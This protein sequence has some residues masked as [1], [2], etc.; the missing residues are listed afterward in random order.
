MTNNELRAKID[1]LIKA[2]GAKEITGPIMN[3]ILNDVVN[4]YEL[5]DIK[6]SNQ[7]TTPTPTSVGD[8]WYKPSTNMLFNWTGSVWEALDLSGNIASLNSDDI[9]EGIVNLFVTSTEKGNFHIQNTD[10]KISDLGAEINTT[11][12]QILV[13]GNSI[14]NDNVELTD[15]VSVYKQLYMYGGSLS[16]YLKGIN[17]NEFQI[18][19]NVTETVNF[20]ENITAIKNDLTVSGSY[21]IVYGAKIWWSTLNIETTNLLAEDDNRNQIFAQKAGDVISI[22]VYIEDL[23]TNTNSVAVNFKIGA[24]YLIATFQ[25]LIVGWN[26]FTTLQNTTVAVNDEIKMEVFPA[27]GNDD[28]GDAELYIE[29][30]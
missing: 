1:A 24:N 4:T 12:G 7:E 11:G 21:P 30:Q 18:V 17:S 8:L 15:V 5:R 10:V 27:S 26:T 20:T 6:F 29:V 14:F 23:G 13:T 9:I 3:T 2:N 25:T 19:V 16:T 28:I 22:Q